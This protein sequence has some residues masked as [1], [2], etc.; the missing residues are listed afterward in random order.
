MVRVLDHANAVMI[1][2]PSFAAEVHER[3]GTAM[4]RFTFIP[5]AVDTT[6]FTPSTLGEGETVR[7]L[8]HG[9][10][11]A[12][13]GV[14]DFIEACAHVQGSWSATVSG[15]GPDLGAAKALV[16]ERGLQ[17]RVMFTGY[18][19]YADVPSIYH[20]HQ[21]FASPTYAEGFS[22][23]ILEAMASGL[24]IVSCHAVGVSDALRD[25]ENGLLVEPGDVPA[26]TAALQ[27][28]IDEPGLRRRLADH[29]LAECRAT[30]SWE[31]VAR[32][33]GKVYDRIAQGGP[34]APFDEALPHDPSC[35]FRREPH[36]L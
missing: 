32:M 16:A 20:G 22:N 25:G 19:D 26:L 34:P 21:V 1:G 13:K 31:V 3:L 18:A 8:Y 14:L 4:A 11:D 28:L 5:G 27:L 9:R 35:R 30:Y 15:I 10:V 23:T 17:D 2:G 29:A 12:R 6:R 33:I 36:L 7:I 24:A